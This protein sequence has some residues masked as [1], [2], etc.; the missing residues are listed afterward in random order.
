MKKENK[1][2]SIRHNARYTIWCLIINGY[3]RHIDILC[4][5]IKYDNAQRTDFIISSC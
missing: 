5:Y 2:I 4:L 3:I 1:W